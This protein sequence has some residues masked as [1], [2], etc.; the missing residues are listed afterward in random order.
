M[1]VVGQSDSNSVKESLD[2]LAKK[3]EIDPKLYALQTG[4]RDDIID[5]PVNVKGVIFHIPLLSNDN[6]YVLWKC[7]WPDCHNCCERQGRLPLTKD[8]IKTIAKKI[9]Y[10]SEV[11]FLKKETIVST[12]QEHGTV[13][14]LITTLTMISLKRQRDEQADQDGKPLKCR[15]LDDKVGA[16]KIHP[17]KPGVC[18]LYPF[19]SW[20]EANQPGKPPIVHATFQFTG[21]CPGFYLD[22]SIESMKSVLHEYSDKIYDYNMAVS[23]TTRENY[24][25]VNFVDL[26]RQ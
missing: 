2:Q 7:L 3:W 15:F 12:W 16:C 1:I 6:L 25:F 4:E 26:R 19:A 9:G 14:N 24:G 10:V 22:K 20:L 11:E 18:W 21:D 13:E 17:D 5:V 8:D 23:R